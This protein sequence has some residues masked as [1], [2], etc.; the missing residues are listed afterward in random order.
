[1]LKKRIE[2]CIT[3]S[4]KQAMNFSIHKII[5]GNEGINVSTFGSKN[6]SDDLVKENVSI[7][8]TKNLNRLKPK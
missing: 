1:M 7:F 2:V 3:T 4:P 8:I 5:F 6:S